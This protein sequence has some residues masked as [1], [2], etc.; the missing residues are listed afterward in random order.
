[1]STISVALAERLTEAHAASGGDYVSA[2]VFGRPS[3]AENA[4]LAVVAAGDE[5]V[6]TVCDHPSSP[7]DIDAPDYK[8]A[9]GASL[10]LA[11]CRVPTLGFNHERKVRQPWV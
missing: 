1:M 10:G 6:L 3:A 9:L 4:K 11:A 5:K 7:F 8:R 2:P